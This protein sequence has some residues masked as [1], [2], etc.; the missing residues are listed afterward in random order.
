MVTL[1]G[2]ARDAGFSGT[3]LAMS[4]ESVARRGIDLVVAAIG[5]LALLVPMIVIGLLIRATS[6]GPALFQQQRVGFGGRTFTMFKFRTMRTGTG[7]E[8]LRE[9]IAAELR[10]EDTS[11]NGSF[12][13]DDDPRVTKVGNFLRKT[14]L[15]ELPQLI[16][17]MVGNMSL[18]GP[19]PCL[20]WEAR[21]FPA[22]FRPRFSVRPGLTGLW[23]VS[24]RST[25]GTLEM[26]HLDLTYVR[27]R[28]LIGDLS[29]LART[30]PSMLR[31]HSAR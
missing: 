18:V 27:T 11:S 7:D 25:M 16:N 8:M 2:D 21:M 13:L 9:L 30:I 22:E 6:T 4:W 3:L 10:G 14:S 12:K 1:G 17:V 15:D 24:G 20:V 26:L 5:L 29:I 31:D 28:H 23:Q 19:R